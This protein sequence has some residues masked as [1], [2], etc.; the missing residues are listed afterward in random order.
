MK[1]GH[2]SCGLMDCRTCRSLDVFR[3]AN[4]TSECMF[5]LLK[6]SHKTQGC[7]TIQQGILAIACLLSLK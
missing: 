1:G 2:V 7:A 4:R 3:S 6:I 5:K